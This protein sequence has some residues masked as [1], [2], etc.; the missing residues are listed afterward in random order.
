MNPLPPLIR[1]WLTSISSIE[2]LNFRPSG[3]GSIRYLRDIRLNLPLLQAAI[4]YWDPTAHVFR[5]GLN[6]ICPTVEEFAAYLRGFQ[7][8]V[9]IIPELNKSMSRVLRSK[10]GLSSGAATFATRGDTLNIQ[11]LVTEFGPV[12]DEDD[13]N[14]QSRRRFALSIC[15]LAAYFLVS[16]FG[17]VNPMLVGIAEQIGQR[18]NVVP[19]ILGETLVGLDQVQAGA[20]PTFG[21]SPL[22]LQVLTQLSFFRLSHFLILPHSRL[23]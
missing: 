8:E 11:Y 10:L 7:S 20:T 17:P 22:L 6:E 21:G 2:W 13:L 1:P 16:S 5:F 4:A 9:P 15:V 14:W 23:G 12:G 3:L 18:K 19:L